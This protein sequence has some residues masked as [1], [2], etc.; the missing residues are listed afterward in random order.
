MKTAELETAAAGRWAW[1]A[2]Q[3][4][5]MRNIVNA[6]HFTDAEKLQ[7]ERMKLVLDF[8]YT[9]EGVFVNF[10]KHKIAVKVSGAEV[11]DRVLLNELEAEWALKGIRKSV[12]A[13]GVIYSF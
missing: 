11:K 7:A 2:S 1:A 13:Q 3:N 9:H 12:T 8:V 6:S 5:R 10:R 4:A